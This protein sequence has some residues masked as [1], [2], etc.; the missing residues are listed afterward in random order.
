MQKCALGL[1]MLKIKV[2]L[3][4]ELCKLL[5]DSARIIYANTYD[6]GEALHFLFRNLAGWRTLQK[7]TE[8]TC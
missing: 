2:V 7:T 4:L 8:K 5:L 6:N 3:G 1:Q